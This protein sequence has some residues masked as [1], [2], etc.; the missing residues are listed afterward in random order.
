MPRAVYLVSVVYGSYTLAKF[1]DKTVWLIGAMNIDLKE[2][3]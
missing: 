2:Y 3:T 1:A